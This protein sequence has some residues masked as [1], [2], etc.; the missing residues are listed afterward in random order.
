MPRHKSKSKIVNRPGMSTKVQDRK[1]ARKE[2]R[3]GKKRNRK[4]YNDKLHPKEPEVDKPTGDSEIVEP[5][6]KIK[7]LKPELKKFNIIGN[8]ADDEIIASLGAKL[9][10][11]GDKKLRKE[12]GEEMGEDFMDFLEGLEGIEERLGLKEEEEEE[13][14]ERRPKKKKEKKKKK[15]KGMF[16]VDGN[17]GDDEIIASLGAKLAKKGDKKLRKE[18]GEEMGEDF[19]DFLDDLDELEG[20]L[21]GEDEESD[22]DEDKDEVESGSDIGD[23]DEDEDEDGDED[24]DDNDDSE[25]DE[26]SEDSSS[27]LDDPP[28]SLHTYTPTAGEDIYGRPTVQTAPTTTAKYVPPHLRNKA[29]TLTTPTSIILTSSLNKLSSSNLR[30]T[31]ISLTSSGIPHTSILSTFLTTLK[32]YDNIPPTSSIYQNIKFIHLLSLLS[33]FLWNSLG[34]NILEVNF[35]V[36]FNCKVLNGEIINNLTSIATFYI[37]KKISTKF[38][39]DFLLLILNDDRRGVL[40]TIT[41]L[42]YILDVCGIKISKELG[43][44]DTKII[45]DI[46]RIVK[47]LKMEEGRNDNGTKIEYMKENVLTKIKYLTKYKGKLAKNIQAHPIISDVEM[48]KRMLKDLEE[49]VKT[50]WKIENGLGL[51]VDDFIHLEKR[52]RWWKVGEVYNKDGLNGEKKEEAKEDK[53]EDGLDGMARKLKMTTPLRKKILGLLLGSFD[54]FEFHATLNSL[55]LNQNDMRE[56]TRVVV[57]VCGQEKKFNVY[58]LNILKRMIEE[59][60]KESKKTICLMFKDVVKDLGGNIKRARNLGRLFGECVV[61]GVDFFWVG[62][63]VEWLKPS[64]EI[65]V[66]GVYCFSVV[67]GVFSDIEIEGFARK[68]RKDRGSSDEILGFLGKFAGGWKGNV[69]GSEWRRKWKTCMKLMQVG[70]GDED[71][72][73]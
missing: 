43:E 17:E 66:F 53:V 61:G 14:E 4:E 9:S 19:M 47:G 7:K 55:N 41:C 56:A 69:K 42:N 71:A 50:E 16:E 57:D 64:E 2:K 11:K 24:G 48:R 72:D 38:L 15:K 13:E 33:S 1:L 58:Y 25:E 68:A 26:D 62:R 31:L 8:E 63:D 70:G 73:M 27:P 49:N 3:Q 39:L 10:K 21:G 5:V 35:K 30:Q 28:S 54:A 45:Q 44:D 29:S 46:E 67:F 40:E 65:V 52:G 6:K 18:Y 34:V 22:E 32:T 37:M 60:G 23:S 36:I 51:K 59:E 20:R 12:Y